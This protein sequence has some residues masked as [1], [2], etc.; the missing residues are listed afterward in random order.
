[1]A[2]NYTEANLNQVIFNVLTKEQ[3]EAQ[4][5]SGT[6]NEKE[7]YLIPDSLDLPDINT[8]TSGKVLTN[9][10][11]KVLWSEA[12]GGKKVYNTEVNKESFV[13]DSTYPQY[14]YKCDI[15]I[16]DVTEDMIPTVLFNTSD[17]IS[18]IYST[19]AESYNGYIRIF[20]KIKPEENLIIP[21][22]M[23]Q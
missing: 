21:I 23:F 3:Y 14:A 6:I 13:L 19:V 18:G 17:A 15:S 1:M 20:S 10:G 7:F 22:I 9:D 5:S 12:S 4:E 11:T 8:S 16:A 2:E